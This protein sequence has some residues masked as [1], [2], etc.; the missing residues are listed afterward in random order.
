[1]L[2]PRK[3]Q[4]SASAGASDHPLTEDERE[5]DPATAFGVRSRVEREL[6]GDDFD[7]D[8]RLTID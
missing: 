2:C 4:R 6:V 5:H 8:E 3:T 1:V 7:P